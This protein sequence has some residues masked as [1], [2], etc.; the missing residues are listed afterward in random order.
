MFAS[1]PGMTWQVSEVKKFHPRS[2]NAK[3]KMHKYLRRSSA[4]FCQISC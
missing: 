4:I 2:I 3:W 1:S